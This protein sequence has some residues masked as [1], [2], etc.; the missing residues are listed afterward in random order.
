DALDMLNSG[1]VDAFVGNLTTTSYYIGQNKQ[2]NIHVAGETPYSNQQTIAVRKDWPLF[3]GIIQKSLNTIKQEERDAIYNRWMSIRYEHSNDYTLLWQ[4]LAVGA[5]IFII[6]LYWN[7]LLRR[8]VAQR[9]KE[10][11]ESEQRFRAIIETSPDWIWELDSHLNFTY[12]SPKIFDLLGYTANDVI[13]KS[14]LELMPENE[15]ERI[16]PIINKY[17][18]KK[19]PVYQLEN[20]KQHKDGSRIC[21]ESNAVPILDSNGLFCGYRGVS[22][23]ISERK[24]N[25]LLQSELQQSQ[26][27]ESLGHL[28]GGIAHDFN[29]L[30]GVINGYT[31]LTISALQNRN[32]EKL[33]GYMQHVENA[34]ERAAKLVSLMLTY[35]RKDSSAA[36]PI[37]IKMHL[38]DDILMLRAALL[39]SI[40]FKVSIEDDIPAVV[41]IPIQLNQILMNLAI[42]A[43]DAMNESGILSLSLSY[44]HDVHTTDSV[45]KKLIEG[46]WV[47]LSISDNGE[48]IDSETIEHIF[49]PFFTTKDVGK[50]TGM[51]LSVIYGIMESHHG[52]IQVESGRGKGTTFK[53]FFPPSDKSP[54]APE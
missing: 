15:A 28:T 6:I 52:H 42:N 44:K 21:L 54:E 53:L 3:A 17:V 18:V 24:K 5:L 11:Q 10:A 40:E 1:A 7:S 26:K 2:Y 51:G 33:V 32:E 9:T 20:S 8:K 23:D 19:E 37:D 38:S 49:N 14:V 41:M 36:R 27:M 48:G 35:S 4:M 47:I 12:S 25:D 29:N 45:S 43:R 46:D 22:R 16:I 39:S 50:G 31:E 13:G 30:L 34:G